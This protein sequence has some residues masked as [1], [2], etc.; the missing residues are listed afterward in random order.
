MHDQ[1]RLEQ[2]NVEGKVTL[3]FSLRYPILLSNLLSQ[4]AITRFSFI[5]QASELKP[6]LNHLVSSDRQNH[7]VTVRTFGCSRY[8][9]SGVG[10]SISDDLSLRDFW[11]SIKRVIGR[12]HIG[13]TFCIQ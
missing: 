11:Q 3:T 10:D 13:S 4:V 7:C 9:L 8:I 12:I 1:T 2:K 6:V 5:K